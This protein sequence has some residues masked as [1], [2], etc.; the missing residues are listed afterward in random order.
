MFHFDCQSLGTNF[1]LK[2]LAKMTKDVA[3]YLSDKTG[4]EG[5]ISNP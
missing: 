5:P 1:F 3:R 4:A 2:T